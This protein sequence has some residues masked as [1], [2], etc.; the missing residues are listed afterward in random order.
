MDE[1]EKKAKE[2]QDGLELAKKAD[3]E[4]T[5]VKSIVESVKSDVEGVKLGID[6]VKGDIDKIQSSIEDIAK[7]V[8]NSKVIEVEKKNL[9]QKIAAILQS[10]EYKAQ[11]AE[12]K[13]KKRDRTKV[14]ETKDDPTT[15]VTSG[16]TGDV[17]RTMA[18]E[19]FTQGYEPNK[20][21]A[22][23]TPVLVPQN[24]NKAMWF[25]G[26]YYDNVGYVTELTALSTGDGATLEEKSRELA[27]VGAFLPYSEEVADD[28]D[29]FLNWAVNE[30][31]ESVLGK[32]D[33]LIYTGVGADGGAYTKNIYGLK[34]AGSTA[35]NASTAGLALAV[36]NATI[37]D[38]VRAMQNQIRIQTNG[39]YSGNLL[40]AHPALIAQ[41][42][43]LKN[44]QADYINIMPNGSMMIWGIPVADSTKVGAAELML[45]D[46]R[47]M[48]LYQKGSLELETERI[49][50][51]DSYKLHLRWR[52]QVVVPTNAKLGNVYVANYVTAI[53]ALNA[54]TPTTLAPTTTAAPTTA[55]PT[56]TVAPTTT[57]S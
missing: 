44:T 42:Y 41:L 31:I 32:I 17:T 48:K 14:F 13:E 43:L 18:G 6:G 16:L 24:K 49:A 2:I 51:T 3:K 27:K 56:T 47:T 19:I 38:L 8:K 45:V 54:V 57:G 34:T 9:K 25:D 23:I 28:M 36:S 12:L 7:D 52:G 21:L 26:A 40:Y 20:F 30:G 4:V 53:A 10:D 37:A 15:V 29:Y 39:K 55:A 35:F 5:E 50:S 11:I 22:N 46:T 1:L 33:D